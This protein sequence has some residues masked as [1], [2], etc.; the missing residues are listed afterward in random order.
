[1]SIHDNIQRISVKKIK[2]N[3][4]NPN[5][6]TEFIFEKERASIRKFG[7]L[8]PILV[9]KV[10]ATYE[11]IDGEHRFRAAVEEGFKEIPCNVL[12]K[13][14]DNH[15]KQLTI[16]LNETRG[17][18]RR[19]KLG[20]LLKDLEGSVGLEELLQ[21]LPFSQSEI[22][23]LTDSIQIDWTKI[24]NPSPQV[25][26]GL[27]ETSAEPTPQIGDPVPNGPSRV[28]GE[29]SQHEYVKIDKDVWS[30]LQPQLKRVNKGLAAVGTIEKED[31]QGAGYGMA[32]QVIAQHFSE[33]TDAN[34]KKMLK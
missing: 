24:E 19:D 6:Q 11:I 3:P 14:T 29:E 12:E 16:I 32:F 1:M 30:V 18:A 23:N 8:M 2:A 28:I 34:I 33:L 5:E 20:E 4:W 13:I 9:R 31:L 7:F 10:K 21:T 25:V 26:Q 22:R 15:A 17:E 27:T